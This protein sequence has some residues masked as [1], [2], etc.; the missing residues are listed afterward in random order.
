MS[1]L[2]YHSLGGITYCH[3]ILEVVK[4]ENI[5]YRREFKFKSASLDGD[6]LS[7]SKSG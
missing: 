6:L 1:A 3:S 2:Q 7:K 4:V 5:K